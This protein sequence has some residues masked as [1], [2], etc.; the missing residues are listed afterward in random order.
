[1][2]VFDE[3]TGFTPIQ[4]QLLRK[5]LVLSER[6]IVS[7]T[8]DAGED[9]YHCRGEQE[10]FS[11]SKK[12]VSVLMKMAEEL[13]VTVEEPVVLSDG[14]NHRY[15]NAPSLYFMEQNLFRPYYHKWR[16]K[17]DE[18][19]IVSLKNPREELHFVA[20]EITKFVREKQYCYK[21]IAVVT[22]D[23]SLYD[24]YVDEIFAA[25]DIPYFLDQTRTIL[26]HPFIEFIRAVLEVVELDFSY[27]SVFRFSALRSD[28]YHRAADRSAGKLCACQRDTRQKKMGKTVDVCVR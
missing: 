23:V 14:K 19:R 17:E 10:L 16:Q 25:Y 3:F 13:H 18:L 4:N 27:E 2:I 22:G 28:R 24:N 15:K 7:V 11:M 1:M 20:R 12:T 21:D 8:M 26:F 9:F 6:I 5:L